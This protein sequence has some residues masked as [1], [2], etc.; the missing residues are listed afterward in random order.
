MS[1]LSHSAELSGPLFHVT[2]RSSALAAMLFHVAHP[3]DTAQP[4]FGPMSAK[5]FHVKRADAVRSAK[6]EM[7]P[8][9]EFHVTHGAPAPAAMLFHVTQSCE[10]AQ[11][12]LE[13]R[14][15]P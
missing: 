13:L 4:N 12:R 10:P 1:Q 7:N 6:V 5:T 3:C 11:K 14:S 9:A 8:R 15:E 2:Q